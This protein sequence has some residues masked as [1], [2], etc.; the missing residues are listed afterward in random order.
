MPEKG[1]GRHPCALSDILVPYLLPV[2]PIPSL[3]CPYALVSGL[4]VLVLTLGDVHAVLVLE[5]LSF[6]DDLNLV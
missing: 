4:G 6:H 5:N 1:E 3:G 2:V